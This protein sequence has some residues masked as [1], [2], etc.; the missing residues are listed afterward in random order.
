[1]F[2]FYYIYFVS[3]VFQLILF[4]L[5]IWIMNKNK[6]NY[7]GRESS[8]CCNF[9]KHMQIEKAPANQEKI[10]FNLISV[11]ANVHNANK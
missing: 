6:Q 3:A 2:I 8:T 10:F 4:I 7:S 1:M 5:L 11:A 9:R